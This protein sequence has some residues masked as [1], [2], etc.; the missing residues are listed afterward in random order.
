MPYLHETTPEKEAEIAQNAFNSNNLSDAAYHIGTALAYQP[1]KPEWLALLDSVIER[2]PDVL[3][4][5]RLD[6]KRSDFVTAATRAYALA[7]LDRKKEA[8]SLL[9]DAV[10]ARPDVQF[11]S[12]AVAW[13]KAPGVG[14]SY[15][16][17]EMHSEIVSPAASV[18][19][20][21]PPGLPED[22]PLRPTI[23]AFGGIIGALRQS[24]PNDARLLFIVSLIT[25]RLGLFDHSIQFAYQAFQNDSN[26][27][28]ASV[29]ACAYRN[30][31]K[32]EEAVQWFEH[33]L[34]LDAEELSPLLDIGGTHLDADEH[35]N[36]IAA[37]KRALA[38]NP[39]FSKAQAYIHYAT[40]K[41]TSD[42]A[43]KVA[44]LRLAEHSGDA[45]NLFSELEPVINY[46]SQFPNIIDS[47]VRALSQVMGMLEE[48]PERGAGG[49][50][51]VGLDFLESPSV[52][53]AFNLWRASKGFDIEINLNVAGLQTPDPRVP[54]AQIQAVLWAYDGYK[55]TPNAAQPSPEVLEAVAKIA[56]QPYYVEAYAIEAKVAAEK[57]GVASSAQLLGSMVYPPPLPDGMNPFVWLQQCQIAAALV[58]AQLDE[59]WSGSVRKAIL[60][61]LAI[62]QVD[63]TV[64]AS[65]IALS[66]LSRFDAVI[67]AEV[68]ALF[69]WLRGTVSQQGYTCFEFALACSWWAIGS[70][71]EKAEAELAGWAQSIEMRYAP[72]PAGPE[73]H[74]GLTLEEYAEFSFTRDEALAK[75]GWAAGV[76]AV[77]NAE[78][79]AELTELCKRFR[80]NPNIV[81]NTP[82]NAI[83]R[84]PEWDARINEDPAVQEMHFAMMNDARLKSQGIE[85]NSHEGRVAE[86]IRKGRF[87]VEAAAVDAAAAAEQ[88]SQ[89]DAGDPDPTVFPGQP[90]AK[91]SDYVGLMKHMQTGDMAG[92]LAQYGLDMG[93]YATAAQAWG[94]KLAADPVLNA[95]FS[96]MMAS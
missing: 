92:A 5:L 53:N 38:K 22:H 49:S 85:F 80:F 21:V 87:D 9:C 37:Y 40:Y 42:P 3:T 89:G 36:A 43:E 2:S 91:L 51:D 79:T 26:W 24:Q 90:C 23:R 65:I 11:L 64:N 47:S 27:N 63:W 4:L 31:G 14:E 76:L 57:L 10:A 55:A 69:K 13:I 8:V 61:E 18:V 67:R 12:W 6:A 28:T 7:K 75:H 46:V 54:K 15:T 73:V 96:E 70:H 32:T 66:W 94:I 59:G 82:G 71:G 33:C 62:G 16:L 1:D 30:A 77:A 60:W 39:E 74:G 83:G 50:M 34:K 78:L 17:D 81:Q 41:K 88:I 93:T 48:Q 56:S 95:K 45:W 72:K 25:G 20:Q 84:I 29:L 52:L 19:S 68:I 86:D 35:D 44:L 58:I